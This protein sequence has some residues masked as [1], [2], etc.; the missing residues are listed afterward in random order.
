M[1]IY[2][3]GKI[4]DNDWRSEIVDGINDDD[5]VNFD[6]YQQAIKVLADYI[7]IMENE[8]KPEREDGMENL[9][10]FI[11][12]FDGLLDCWDEFDENTKQLFADEGI[13]LNDEYLVCVNIAETIIKQ[14]RR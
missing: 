14:R 4:S 12:Y 13:H 3:A 9:K 11:R 10:N 1:N 8:Y 5:D 6:D 2:L 7:G